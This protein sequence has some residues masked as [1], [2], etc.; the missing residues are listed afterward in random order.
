MARQRDYKAEYARRVAKGKAAGLTRGQAAGH[1]ELLKPLVTQLPKEQRP[2][3]SPRPKPA[4]RPAPERTLGTVKRELNGQRTVLTVEQY[5]DKK[6]QAH[7]VTGT[8]DIYSGQRP[9]RLE[10]VIERVAAVKGDAA[11]RLAVNVQ[12]QWLSVWRHGLN[13]QTA[14]AQLASAGGGFAFIVA[15]LGDIYGED[16]AEVEALDPYDLE[17]E[18]SVEA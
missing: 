11:L 6:G 10:H 4:P 17:W 15:V 18:L 9:Q 16:S 2:A 3:P 8:F 1:P 7:N 12:G 5:T 13:A 14:A